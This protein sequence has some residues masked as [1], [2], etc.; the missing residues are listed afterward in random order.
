MGC[1]DDVGSLKEKLWLSSSAVA[2]GMT[3]RAWPHLPKDET[4]KFLA[5]PWKKLRRLAYPASFGVVTPTNLVSTK[6][7]SNCSMNH[8]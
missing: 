6:F 1:V 3:F 4:Q 7:I 8:L 5:P 2:E